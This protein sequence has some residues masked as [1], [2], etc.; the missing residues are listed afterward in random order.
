MLNFQFF[1]TCCRFLD[2][3]VYG[4]YPPEMRQLLGSRLPT[5]S[6]EER[7]KLGYKLDFIGVNHYT[8]LYAKDCMFS[9]GCPLGQQTQPALVA[10]TEERNGIPIGPP[11]SLTWIPLVLKHRILTDLCLDSYSMLDLIV[12]PFVQTPMPTFY[13]VPD[14][15]AKIV[16]YVMKRYNNLPMFITE[17]GTSITELVQI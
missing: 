4:D 1:F 10:V 16:T 13:V 15:I 12:V 2:P 17:N 9:A 14:G 3:I 6:P 5:F 11:V 8:T 7:R